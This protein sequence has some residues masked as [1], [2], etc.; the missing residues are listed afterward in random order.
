MG[1]WEQFQKKVWRRESFRALSPDARLVYLWSWTNPDHANL[2]GLYS[3]SPR[4]MERALA[5]D[6]PE[7]RERLRAALRELSKEPLV[8][9]DNDNEVLWV[10][11]RVD[12]VLKSTTQATKMAREYEECPS[13]PLKDKFCRTYG[14]KLSLSQR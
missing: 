14:K 4:Q 11:G 1:E 8:L 2:S 9:Y 10:V 6:S 3:A 5:D 7:L 12:H 13:S